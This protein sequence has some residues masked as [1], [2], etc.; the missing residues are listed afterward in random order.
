MKKELHFK[1]DHHHAAAISTES[2]DDFNG[3]ERMRNF[4]RTAKLTGKLRFR[5]CQRRKLYEKRTSF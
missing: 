4:C 1:P 3:F 2:A 5:S